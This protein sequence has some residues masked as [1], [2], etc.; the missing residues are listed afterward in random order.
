MKFTCDSKYWLV[1]TWIS[2]LLFLGAVDQALG[3]LVPVGT[4]SFGATFSEVNTGLMAF[5]GNQFVTVTDSNQPRDTL[6]MQLIDDSGVLLQDYADAT[7]SIISGFSVQSTVVIDR[8]SNGVDSGDNISSQIGPGVFSFVDSYDKI[9]VKGAFDSATFASDHSGNSGGI[10]ASSGGGLTLMPGPGFAFD[11]TSAVQI[12]NP[13]GLSMVLTGINNTGIT[14]SDE[15]ELLMNGTSI[16]IFSAT[17]NPF[18]LSKGTVMHSG[19]LVVVP[20]PGALI[21]WVVALLMYGVVACTILGGN[22]KVFL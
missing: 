18:S 6:R 19:D 9:I 3:T 11:N 8:S 10:I 2:G 20:E 13:D 15:V 1:R 21:M 5:D 7:F 22:A 4:Y 14:T 12:L 17:L 16:G